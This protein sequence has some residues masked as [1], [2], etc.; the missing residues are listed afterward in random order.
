MAKITMK[1]EGVKELIVTFKQL[2]EA[3]VEQTVQTMADVV[4]HASERAVANAPILSAMLRSEIYGEVEGQQITERMGPTPSAITADVTNPRGVLPLAVTFAR[5]EQEWLR[6]SRLISK[7]VN[8][9]VGGMLRKHR[10]KGFIADNVEYA[11]FMHE[12]T[13]NL[14]P[15]SSQQPPT[16]EGGVGNRYISRCVM[17]HL[18]KYK[19]AFSEVPTLA[20]MAA[21]TRVLSM[22]TPSVARRVERELRKEAMRRSR[23][24]S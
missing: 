20:A 1:V 22:L 19:K 16:P 24:G 2:K 8:T 14:G 15:I 9:A 12:G 17:F 23:R 10:L 4:A 6:T 11:R 5:A 21:M 7:R 18:D 3:L 13:Y